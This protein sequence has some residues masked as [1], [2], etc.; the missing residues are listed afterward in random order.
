MAPPVGHRPARPASGVVWLLQQG[1]EGREA[2]VWGA[3][4][5]GGCGRL[6][7]LSASLESA[8][9][10]PSSEEGR[11]RRPTKGPDEAMLGDLGYLLAIWGGFVV[12]FGAEIGIETLSSNS[13]SQILL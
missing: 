2:D 12:D 1:G 4:H 10:A 11:P 3:S 5:G 7:P 13:V 8:K 9:G 6:P